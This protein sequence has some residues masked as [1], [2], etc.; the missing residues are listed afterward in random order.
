MKKEKGTIYQNI[1]AKRDLRNFQ[2]KRK[3]AR[4]DDSSRNVIKIIKL[5]SSKVGNRN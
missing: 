5:L 3:L 4:E 1:R 2:Y